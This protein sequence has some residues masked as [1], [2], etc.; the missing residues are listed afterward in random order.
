VNPPV[1]S[2][3]EVPSADG[4]L[5]AARAYKAVAD[6]SD[7]IDVEKLVTL[8]DSKWYD[9]GRME[10]ERQSRLKLWQRLNG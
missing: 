6:A 4:T 1:V 10:H 5:L 7:S 9:V 3:I 8:T 2:R